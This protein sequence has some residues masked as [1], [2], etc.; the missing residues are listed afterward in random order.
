MDHDPPDSEWIGVW[1]GHEAGNGNGERFDEVCIEYEDIGFHG[2]DC[3]VI[4]CEAENSG[5]D[6]MDS[7]TQMVEF[8]R[9]SGR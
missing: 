7:R 9:R 3:C 4:I 6:G 8:S 1:T 2:P 5:R